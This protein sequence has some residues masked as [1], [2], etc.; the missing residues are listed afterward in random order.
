MNDAL[1]IHVVTGWLIQPPT[2]CW[3]GDCIISVQGIYDGTDVKVSLHRRPFRLAIHKPR[4]GS[5]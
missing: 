4:K 5:A 2:I 1:F 3:G